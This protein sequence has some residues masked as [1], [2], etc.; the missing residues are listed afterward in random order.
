MDKQ[1]QPTTGIVVATVQ[2]MQLRQAALT[3]AVSMAAICTTTPHTVSV[4][5]DTKG[6]RTVGK[7]LAT[8]LVVTNTGATVT[9]PPTTV[10]QTVSLAATTAVTLKVPAPASAPTANATKTQNPVSPTVAEAIFIPV[11]FQRVRTVQPATPGHAQVAHLFV[12]LPEAQPAATRVTV[13]TPSVD[14]R[15]P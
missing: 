14:V 3:I 10:G 12:R 13:P 15:T 1:P 4:R 6:T 11:D 8:R 2:S 5:M 7:P 9:R